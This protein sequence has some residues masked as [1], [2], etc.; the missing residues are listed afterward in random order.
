MGTGYTTL[1][2][3]R[4]ACTCVK[5]E[6]ETVAHAGKD[7]HENKQTRHARNVAFA[8]VFEIRAPR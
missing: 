1:A 4:R 5:A 7:E 2:M 3:R 8:R 6:H